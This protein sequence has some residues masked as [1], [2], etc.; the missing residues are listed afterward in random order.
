MARFD[1]PADLPGQTPVVWRR[2]RAAIPLAALLR[3]E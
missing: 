3:S 1:T 2:T